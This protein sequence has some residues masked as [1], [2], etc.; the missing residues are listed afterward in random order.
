MLPGCNE[1]PLAT[2]TR[3][4]GELMMMPYGGL[5]RDDD[6]IDG[7][8]GAYAKKKAARPCLYEL[9]NIV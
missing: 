2:T 3:C 4:V 8:A 9:V 1:I 6:G 5:A 7:V